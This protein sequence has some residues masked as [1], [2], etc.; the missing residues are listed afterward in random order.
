MMF[1]DQ[2]SIDDMIELYNDSNYSN[3]VYQ[4]VESCLDQITNNSLLVFNQYID[5]SNTTIK[6]VFDKRG[7]GIVLIPFYDYSTSAHFEDDG[8]W[9]IDRTDY[10][11]NFMMYGMISGTYYAH[12]FSAKQALN[13]KDVVSLVKAM[14]NPSLTGSINNKLFCGHNH[15]DRAITYWFAKYSG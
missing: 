10:Y 7:E 12:E 1:K 4:F 3:I 14:Y 13:N 8:S 5:R 15:L 6:N 11:L 9:T 2:F